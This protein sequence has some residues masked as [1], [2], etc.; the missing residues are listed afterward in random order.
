LALLW[1]AWAYVPTLFRPTR[2][3]R[4]FGMSSA[5]EKLRATLRELEAE[6]TQLQTLD[7]ATRQELITAAAEISAALARGEGRS[8]AAQDAGR[9]LQDRLL[10]FEASHPQLS[11]VISR[12]LDGL[13][14]LGI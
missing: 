1:I 7:E 12:V 8:R 10:A 13:A 11:A 3:P 6:L 9:S 2:F 14:Q 5:S 4:G